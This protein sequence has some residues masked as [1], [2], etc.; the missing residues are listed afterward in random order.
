[1]SGYDAVV[2]L[3]ARARQVAHEQAE[4]YAD[5]V[6]VAERVRREVVGLPGVWDSDVPKFAA[7]EVAAAL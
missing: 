5:M 6:E 4:L 1:M 2:V 3:R 7:A